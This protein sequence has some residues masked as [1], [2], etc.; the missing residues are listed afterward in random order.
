MFSWRGEQRSHNARKVI[1]FGRPKV[2]E[3]HDIRVYQ[4]QIQLGVRVY[5]TVIQNIHAIL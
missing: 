2:I 1:K 5:Q 3:S 4:D